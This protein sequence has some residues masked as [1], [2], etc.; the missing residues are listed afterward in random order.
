MCFLSV[1][2][3]SILRLRALV[4]FATSDNPTFD[5]FE[6]MIW[7]T[8]ELNVGIICAC[9]PSMRQIL[10]RI[11]PRV[12]GGEQSRQRY[13]RYGKGDGHVPTIGSAEVVPQKK[14][15]TEWWQGLSL[16][17]ASMFVSQRMNPAVAR[18]FRES[19]PVEGLPTKGIQVH[20]SVQVEEERPTFVQMQNLRPYAQ[21][22]GPRR[23][24]MRST[25]DFF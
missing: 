3:V 13:Y 23:S 6:T 11:F 4:T 7:S 8:L 2:V 19:T 15:R 9:M 14:G 10:A 1:T 5:N 21:K 12:F 25:F 16:S 18:A 20:R 17:R 24:E 22:P